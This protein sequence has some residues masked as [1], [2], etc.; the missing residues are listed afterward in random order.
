MVAG[1]A[2]APVRDHDGG[3]LGPQA[4]AWPVVSHPGALIG[5]LRALIIQSL[6]PLAMAGVA[7]HSDYRSRALDRLRRTAWYVAAG[8]F[9]DTETARRAGERVRRMHAKVRGT[10]PVT[11]KPY[12]ADDP[13]TQ[14]W[15]HSVEW[16]SFLAAHRVFGP[17]LTPDEEDR[18]IAEGVAIAGL[19]GTPAE[20]V[21]ASVAEMRAYFASVR[22]QLRM[23]EPA[24]EAIEFVLHPPLTREL[25]PVQAPLRVYAN[26]ALALV[27]R[28]LRALAGIDRP[29]ARDAAALA[30]ARPWVAAARFP[31]ARDLA[32]A[33]VGHGVRELHLAA[34][35]RFGS[36]GVE[37]MRARSLRRAA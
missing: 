21:P 27:P 29:A 3:I 32:S 6:H 15:V 17:A 35:A 9:G 13:E 18:Y 34:E 19:V 14:V 26:A 25:I 33:V 11:G 37:G 31:G 20:L 36:L 28:D 8:V 1:A 7:Q 5:G 4:V 2:R 16:H 24:R 23:S 12:S 22:P 10:D 30:L